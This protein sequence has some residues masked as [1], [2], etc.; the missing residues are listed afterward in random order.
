MCFVW[1]KKQYYIISLRMTMQLYLF[2]LF[3]YD[4]E[5]IVK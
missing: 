5:L 4:N 2:E 1:K 3:M